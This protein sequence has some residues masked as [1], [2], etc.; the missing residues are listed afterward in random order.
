[1]G[2]E[3]AAPKKAAYFVPCEINAAT[4]SGSGNTPEAFPSVSLDNSKYR[5]FYLSK[6]TLMNYKK[7]KERMERKEESVKK[8]IEFLAREYSYTEIMTEMAIAQT[9][10]MELTEIATIHG[11]KKGTE[12]VTSFLVAV[13]CL[14]ITLQDLSDFA[15]MEKEDE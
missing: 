15:Q 4:E 3:A 6:F 14:M 9:T 13:Q 11:Y 5:I 10:I 7:M 12:D 8:L 1:M 2:H